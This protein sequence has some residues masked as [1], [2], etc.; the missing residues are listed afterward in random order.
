MLPQKYKAE[1][2]KEWKL[3]TIWVD[4]CEICWNAFV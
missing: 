3:F 1:M 2:K 4:S